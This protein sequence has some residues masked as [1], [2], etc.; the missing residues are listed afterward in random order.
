MSDVDA[1]VDNDALLKAIAYGIVETLWPP[2]GPPGRIAA[3]GAARFVLRD[4]IRQIVPS[5]DVDDALAAIDAAVNGAATLEPDED[6]TAFAVQL[7]ATA[8]RRGLPFDTGESLLV[9]IVLA[10]N[11]A[12]LE[13]GDKRAIAAL[14]VLLD[15]LDSVAAIAG[16]VRCLEQIVYR[17]VEAGADPDALARAICARPAADKTLSICCSCFGPAEHGWRLD[18]DALESYIARLRGQAPRV[19][20]P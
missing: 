20:T 10:R 6:E 5:A 14:D 3:L 18:R 12:S 1:A 2:G 16:R 8:Q 9:A 15:H 11:I 7:E 19:L 13:T 4:H 17:A